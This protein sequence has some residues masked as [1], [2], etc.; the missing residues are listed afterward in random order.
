MSVEELF[1]E[2]MANELS[3][4][5][6]SGGEPF[7]QSKE[8]HLLAKRLKKAGKNIWSYTGFLFEELVKHPD[9]RSLLEEIDVLVDGRFELM[10]RD[11][12]LLYK[13]S[14]NQRI[15]DVPKSLQLHQILYF[16]L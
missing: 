2:V 3:N 7:Q 1:Q 13:G 10:K 8:L 4:V 11:L 9:H 14:S 12:S 5:T 15:I 6:F 16:E